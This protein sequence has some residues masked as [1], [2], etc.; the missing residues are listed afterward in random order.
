VRPVSVTIDGLTFHGDRGP[1][2][3]GPGGFEG[4][5]DGV[6]VRLSDTA[7]PGAH[8]SYGLPA[9]LDA[10]TVSVSGFALAETLLEL[11]TMGERLTGLL[12]H[13]GT[14]R[15]VVETEKGTQWADCQLASTKT[16][17]TKD[18]YT[19]TASF[20]IQVWCPD[21][22]KYGTT[23]SEPLT[24]GASRSLYHY[25]NATSS[26]KVIV[27][28][29]ITGGYTLSSND[30]RQ[31]RV[32]AGIAAGATHEVDMNDGLLRIN[33][34]VT[35]GLVSRGDVWDIKPGKILNM[36]LFADSGS[37]SGEVIIT[38]TFI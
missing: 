37:A 20:Q 31:Y 21:P 25:G 29:P 16:L 14:G 34:R 18:Y 19:P 4:W 30:G 10:R 7:R 35:A 11:D 26:P 2:A 22:R 13:G 32:N 6:D 9:Y 15:I 33:G 38:D 1:W 23:R 12:A 3:I 5:D 27:N 17:F 28:G 36:A 24:G 8:G